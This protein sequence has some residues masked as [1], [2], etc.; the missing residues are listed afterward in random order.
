MPFQLSHDFSSAV[1][2]VH[3]PPFLH[4]FCSLL[5]KLAHACPDPP[6]LLLP[7][8]V[9]GSNYRKTTDY[10]LQGRSL[11]RNKRDGQRRTM[12]HVERNVGKT[13]GNDTLFDRGFCNVTTV[14]RN[15]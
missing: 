7:E 12:I 15:R 10:L 8:K 13:G 11:G 1:N 3:E 14:A 5:S 2:F 4:H 6:E 9:T